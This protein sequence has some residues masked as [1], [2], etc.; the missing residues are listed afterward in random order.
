[1]NLEK[2]KVVE[3]NYGKNKPFHNIYTLWD[4]PVQHQQGSG[5]LFVFLLCLL[6]GLLVQK[7]EEAD[8]KAKPEPY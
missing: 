8:W 5:L 3:L 2:L 4:A 6:L 1:M 7:K